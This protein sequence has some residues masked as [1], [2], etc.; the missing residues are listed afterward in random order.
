MTF[1]LGFWRIDHCKEL[2]PILIG[3]RDEQHTPVHALQLSQQG[4]RGRLGLVEKY[5][6]LLRS[7][8]CR[9]AETIKH[10]RLDYGAY[11]W[12]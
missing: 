8:Y 3:F 7:R 10:I 6:Q 2:G 12:S 5:L 4:K 1:M 11:D 9:E